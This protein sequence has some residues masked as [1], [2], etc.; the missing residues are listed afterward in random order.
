M[1]F[2][3]HTMGAIQTPVDPLLSALE[4][5][6]CFNNKKHRFSD[7][8]A[9]NKPSC[10]LHV[11]F[12]VMWEKMTITGLSWWYTEEVKCKTLKNGFSHISLCV[13]RYVSFLLLTCWLSTP[14]KGRPSRA[15][16]LTCQ[17]N[18]RNCGFVFL[19]HQIGWISVNPRSDRKSM[20]L[21]QRCCIQE[22]TW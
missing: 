17:Q 11:A 13:I 18:H 16:Q 1:G 22:K 8:S 5:Q 14:P 7:I 19:L 10:Q 15:S 12:M 4:E 20:M 21:T 2:V 3:R 9:W 6:S